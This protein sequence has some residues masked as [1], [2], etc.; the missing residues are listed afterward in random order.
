MRVNPAS[1]SVKVVSFEWPDLDAVMEIENRVFTSP[2]SRDSYQQLVPQ[3]PI[4][5][6]VAKEG[7]QVLGYMLYQLW[8]EE[9]ELHTIGVLPEAQ[10]RGVGKLLME[11]LIAEAHYHGVS[12][13]YLQVR[14]SN[15][16]AIRL[17]E[18]FAFAKVGMRRRYYQ[19]NQEDAFVMRWKE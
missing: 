18:R 7:T 4:S 17:Y 9:M 14:V 16:P 13:I 6:W 1:A 10:G 2:W 3:D 15:L 11:K 12:E 8:G 5:M 19:D